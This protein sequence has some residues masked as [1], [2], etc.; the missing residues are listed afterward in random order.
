MSC[1]VDVEEHIGIKQC[2]DGTGITLRQP[3][4][5]RAYKTR[6]TEN[7]ALDQSD[8]AVQK[9]QEIASNL[10]VVHT[11]TVQCLQLMSDVHK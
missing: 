2:E 4:T 5:A 8:E 1:L 7:R 10:K 9:Y 3:V 11:A 6:D